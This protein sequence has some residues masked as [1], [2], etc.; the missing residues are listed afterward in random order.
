[1]WVWLAAVALL[2]SASSAR[3]DWTPGVADL[4]TVATTQ[5]DHDVAVAGSPG[6]LAPGA[7]P[8]TGA[9]VAPRVSPRASVPD[10]PEITRLR[11]GSRI[12]VR[13]PAP[14]KLHVTFERPTAGGWRA[15][16]G[17]IELPAVQRA[18]AR[19]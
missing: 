11:V 18:I 16:P 6:A 4:Q 19:T 3:A 2:V 5:A 9:L 10:A 17:T 1:M 8:V 14:A 12:A 13:L 15:T 7:S